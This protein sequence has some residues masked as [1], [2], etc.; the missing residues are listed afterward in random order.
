MDGGKI[1]IWLLIAFFIMFGLAQIPHK[2][3]EPLI[4]TYGGCK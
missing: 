3:P 2:E 4:Q 1:L